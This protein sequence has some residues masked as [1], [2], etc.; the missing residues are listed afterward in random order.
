MSGLHRCRA[1]EL[2][3]GLID[4]LSHPRLLNVVLVELLGEISLLLGELLDLRQKW[5]LL[6][7]AHEFAAVVDAAHGAEPRMIAGVAA[8]DAEVWA[9][10]D[11]AVEAACRR[12]VAIIN[13]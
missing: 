3:V 10:D 2:D 7:M 9:E 5:V 12:L 11:L 8:N 6:L 13:N 4:H 1:S